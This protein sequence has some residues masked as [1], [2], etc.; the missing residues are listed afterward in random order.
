MGLS[1]C[2][3]LVRPNLNQ[4]LYPVLLYQALPS[5]GETWKIQGRPVESCQN[6]QRVAEADIRRRIAAG[7]GCVQPR[8]E[9]DQGDLTSLAKSKK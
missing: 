8:E 5:S 9:K 2:P 1:I 7:I 4:T 3:A 6:N